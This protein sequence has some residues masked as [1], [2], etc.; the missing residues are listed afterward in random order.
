[1]A[2]VLSTI[3]VYRVHDWVEQIAVVTRLEQFLNEH[4]QVKLVRNVYPRIAVQDKIALTYKMNPAGG[5][6]Q[7]SIPIS[8]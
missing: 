6:R 4:P 2:S 7:C 8:L 5:N 1:M 3:H